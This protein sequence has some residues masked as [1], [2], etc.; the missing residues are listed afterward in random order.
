[1]NEIAAVSMTAVKN[2]QYPHYIFF[3]N[4]REKIGLHALHWKVLLLCRIMP[5]VLCTLNVLHLTTEK[6]RTSKWVG[7]F[8]DALIKK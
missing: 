5:L 2:I 7:S 3:E 4:P 1:M 6:S 8:R